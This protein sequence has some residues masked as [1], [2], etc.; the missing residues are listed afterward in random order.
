M[1]THGRQL[2]EREREREREREVKGSVRAS[3]V[4]GGALTGS[5]LVITSSDRYFKRRNPAHYG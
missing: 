5:I 3:K 1:H 4:V 2:A